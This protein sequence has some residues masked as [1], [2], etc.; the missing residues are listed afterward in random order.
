MKGDSF[1]S[2]QT[3]LW[4]WCPLFRNPTPVGPTRAA[5]LVAPNERGVEQL[6]RHSM[7]VVTV[8]ANQN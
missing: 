4:W 1:T 8:M 6:T 7:S 2:P 3:L 5:V